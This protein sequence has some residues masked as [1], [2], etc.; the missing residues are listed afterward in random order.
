[1]T[2][3]WQPGFLGDRASNLLHRNK[4]PCN[5]A[6]VPKIQPMLHCNMTIRSRSAQM[7]VNHPGPSGPHFRRYDMSLTAEQILASHTTSKP[8]FAWT[9][10]GFRRRGKL[11][12][13]NVTA[14]RAA[15]RPEAANHASRA[16]REGRP[17]LLALQTGLFQPLVEKTAA[18]S[19]HLYD[20]ASGT[21][22]EFGKAF[23]SPGQR[24]AEG[25]HQP[26]GQRRQERPAGSAKPLWP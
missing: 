19:R 15:G 25:F 13:L 22:A 10:Q 6:A 4:N 18:Y 20:I 3:L 12:E 16:G 7:S 26:G 1:M 17:E 9:S 2:R 21:G 14:S 8:C 24:R 11:V 23:R 5:S